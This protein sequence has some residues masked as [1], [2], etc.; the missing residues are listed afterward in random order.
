MNTEIEVQIEKN[1]LSYAAQKSQREHMSLVQHFP[2]E[3]A[4]GLSQDQM[5]VLL[6][7]QLQQTNK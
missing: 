6:A 4:K 7:H 1:Y 3:L 2:F 5:R